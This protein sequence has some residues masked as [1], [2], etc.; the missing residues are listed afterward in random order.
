MTTTIHGA[1]FGLGRPSAPHYLMA[2]A[3]GIGVV[4]ALVV[5]AGPSF[6]NHHVG[7]I[8]LHTADTIADTSSIF[9]ASLDT[10]DTIK[11][12][13]KYY[14]MTGGRAADHGFQV[15]DIT[16]PTNIHAEGQVAAL[17]NIF[18]VNF[19][20]IGTNIYA[21]T[22]SQRDDGIQI[23]NITVPSSPT[24]VATV[25][26]NS[27]NFTKLEEVRHVA[28]IQIGDHHY[29]MA[30]SFEEDG[31]EWMNITN[32]TAPTHVFT[33]TDNTLTEANKAK[34][35]DLDDAKSFFFRQHGSNYY[36][37]IAGSSGVQIVN[38]VT[39]LHFEVV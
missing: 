28:A 8:T 20:Q 16:D 14:I 4:F 29:A 36:A 34:F 5:G 15:L 6:A 10:L 33:G 19:H 35:T 17:R 27:N 1:P 37:Y 39:V 9:L 11:I 2:A 26:D 7:D 24:V 23:I 31:F 18:D 32:V 22:A 30:T 25:R 13:D 21:L 3:L 38:L 12:G